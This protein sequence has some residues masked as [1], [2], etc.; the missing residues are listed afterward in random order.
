MSV[1]VGD[2]A[3]R[4]FAVTDELIEA[5]GDASGDRNP[6]HFDEAY[7]ATTRFGG[8]IAHGMLTAAF[9]SSLLGN[10]LPGQGTIYLRQDI[11]F[12]APVRPGDCV[13]CR[14]EVIDH[15][16]RRRR[17]VLRTQAWVGKTAV[18]DGEATVLVPED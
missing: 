7:A 12:L 2:V 10:D 17:A 1:Q 13:R 15:D 11:R 14:V 9:I 5:F 16:P 4:E 3:E 6:V 18:V 8:R